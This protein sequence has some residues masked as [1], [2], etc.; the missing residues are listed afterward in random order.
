MSINGAML[1]KP[2]VPWYTYATWSPALTTA[3]GI[4]SNWN[5]T[6]SVNNA[7]GG[8][9]PSTIAT[10]GKSSGKW[11]WE[12]EVPFTGGNPSLSY[13]LNGAFFWWVTDQAVAFSESDTI[14]S[15]V[16]WWGYR[17]FYYPWW[18]WSPPYQY[19]SWWHNW[20]Y[21]QPQ[22]PPTGNAGWFAFALDMDDGTLRVFRV[23]NLWEQIDLWIDSLF[24]GLSGTFYPAINFWPGYV[25]TTTANFWATPLHFTP[26][27]WFNAGLYV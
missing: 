16:H 22:Q 10:I 2:Y 25:H 1:L 23:G 4:L 27:V 26:P 12:M 11:Y 14:A 8:T 3:N 7:P 5:L 24:T 21:N 9:Y 13:E 18:G 19:D 6:F 15:S 17:T 20:V